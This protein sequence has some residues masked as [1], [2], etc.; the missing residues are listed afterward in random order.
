MR[1]A[2]SAPLE[3]PAQGPRSRS[4]LKVLAQ[5]PRSRSSLK[6]PSQGSLSRR[7]LKA[8][9]QE[10][11]SQDRR[12]REFGG[13]ATKEHCARMSVVPKLRGFMQPA[14]SAPP[15]EASASSHALAFRDLQASMQHANR[16]DSAG[17]TKSAASVFSC[18]DVRPPDC[19]PMRSV[20]NA[21]PVRPSP[22][23]PSHTGTRVDTRSLSHA[24]ESFRICA[25]SSAT[26]RP[27]EGHAK[28]CKDDR[29][30]RTRAWARTHRPIEVLPF[31]FAADSSNF[32]H[33][34]SS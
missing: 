6:V 33:S 21:V 34:R 16:S 23:S 20:L 13:H 31:I 8:S 28:R 32:Q 12:L 2:G 17:D 30:A 5:G 18:G 7:P 11:A 24:G 22:R 4:P 10:A 14:M 19:S 25:H 29:L 26:R 15:R 27:S 1:S 9:L 3:V